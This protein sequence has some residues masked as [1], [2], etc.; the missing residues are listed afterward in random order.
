MSD[1]R[2]ASEFHNLTYFPG[3]A[4][5]FS[6][7]EIIQITKNLTFWHLPELKTEQPAQHKI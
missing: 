3:L 5:N 1:K 7:G 2:T 4:N 6:R